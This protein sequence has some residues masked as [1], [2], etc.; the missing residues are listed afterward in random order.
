MDSLCIRAFK[1]AGFGEV[2]PREQTKTYNLWIASNRRVRPGEASVKVRNL[3]LFHISQTDPITEA[4]KAEFLAQ[5]EARKTADKLP[6]VC[7]Q[8]SVTPLKPVKG[9]GKPQSQPAA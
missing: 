7:P 4:E 5:K 1:K 8:S 6:P 2:K 9:N 3:R